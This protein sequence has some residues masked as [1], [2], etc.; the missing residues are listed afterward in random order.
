MLCNPVTHDL[1]NQESKP[2][3]TLGLRTLVSGSVGTKVFFI[4]EIVT[5]IR[6]SGYMAILGKAKG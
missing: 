3:S 1:I 4:G 5:I 6:S 2:Q